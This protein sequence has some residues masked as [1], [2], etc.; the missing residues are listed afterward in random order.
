MVGGGR[1][2]LQVGFFVRLPGLRLSGHKGVGTEGAIQS[3]IPP[4]LT[5]ALVPID[6]GSKPIFPFGGGEP[7]ELVELLGFNGVATIVVLAVFDKLDHLLLLLFGE[8][9]NVKEVLGDSQVGPLF[10]D[11]DVVNLS[12]GTLVKDGVES[13]SNVF[14]EDEGASVVSITM[15]TQRHVSL[16]AADEL[17]DEL[18]GVLVRTVDVVTTGNDEGEL[19]RAKI[20]LG[21]EL[22]G[23]FGG[24]VGVGGL[25]NHVF[26]VVLS[27]AFTIDLVCADMDEPLHTATVSGFEENMGSQDVGLSEREG[28]SEGVIDMGLGSEVHNGIDLLGDND[29]A[30]E[31]RRT[32]V[33]FDKL[34]VGVLL[35]L[36][37]VLCAGAIVQA[38]KVD[39]IV[40]GVVLHQSLHDMRTNETGSTGDKDALG[41][42]GVL[43]H[44]GS[45]VMPLCR[46][47]WTKPENETKSI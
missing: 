38:I 36:G 13:P 41:G 45:F 18:L 3:V 25:K 29:V 4:V 10:F 19:E 21:D 34:V 30:N 28:V 44:F 22:G 6:S 5:V 31:I 26:A 12:G 23:G 7:T 11:T 32:D 20:R 39:N 2:G 1:S 27:L 17:G 37:D 9:E 24:R 40:V 35:Q 46:G 14:N 47:G 43:G 33:A 15:D 8:L 42:V 16:E